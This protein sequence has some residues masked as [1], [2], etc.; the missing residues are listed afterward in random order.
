[1]GEALYKRL[2]VKHSL[3]AAFHPQCNSAAES[4]NREIVKYMTTMLEDETTLDWERYLPTLRISYNSAVHKTLLTSPFWLTFLHEPNLPFFDLQQRQAY[5]SD[6]WGTEAYIR[7]KKTYAL[8]NA[9]AEKA[10]KGR[11][12]QSNKT[13]VQKT[14]IVGQ[15]VLVY[16]PASHFGSNKKFQQK[17][18]D[19]YF[20]DRKIGVNTYILKSLEKSKRLTIVH[21]DRLKPRPTDRHPRG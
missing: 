15:K 19:G 17:W 9:N 1:M 14:F 16:Y 13:A 3:T 8:I 2:G 5:Y 4:F 21:A 18:V 20:V 6:D 11:L 12:T 7:L 10:E